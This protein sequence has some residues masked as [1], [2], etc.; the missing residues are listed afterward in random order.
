MAALPSTFTAPTCHV[1]DDHASAGN[2][3]RTPSPACPQLTT[4]RSTAAARLQD[5]QTTAA[6][7]D[8]DM[9][10]AGY[11]IDID[12]GAGLSAPAQQPQQVIE[13]NRAQACCLAKLTRCTA[14]NKSKG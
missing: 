1:S 11:D 8:T 12:V 4:P 2:W 10:D 14:T 9:M 7:D 3:D 5:Y 13:V 6:M